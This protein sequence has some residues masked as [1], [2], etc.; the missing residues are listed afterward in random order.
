MMLFIVYAM[1]FVISVTLRLSRTAFLFVFCL[2]C[3]VVL[4]LFLSALYSMYDINNK[5]KYIPLRLEKR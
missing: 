5:Y 1:H 3:F 4:F 2:S